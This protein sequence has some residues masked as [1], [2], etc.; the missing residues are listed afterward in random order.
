M[1]EHCHATKTSSCFHERLVSPIEFFAK[2]VPSLP[3]KIGHL[4]FFLS[5]QIP[6]HMSLAVFL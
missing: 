4:W 6:S 1:Q 5:E 2:I 3:N